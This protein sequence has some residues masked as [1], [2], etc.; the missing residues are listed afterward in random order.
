MMMIGF[1]PKKYSSVVYILLAVPYFMSQMLH[2][3][4]PT[5][6]K[7]VDVFQKPTTKLKKKLH[8]LKLR[9]E[10]IRPSTHGLILYKN[11]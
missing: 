3:T 7:E 2:A 9:V 11:R 6:A 4:N 8:N 1:D 10:I 5:S